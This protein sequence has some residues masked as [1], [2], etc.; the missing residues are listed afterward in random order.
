MNST[1]NLIQQLPSISSLDK[2]VTLQSPTT[3]RSASGGT[4]DSWADTWTD[5]ARVE[6]SV[7]GNDELI[8][9][10]QSMV[11]YRLKI[12]IRYR[13]TVT[14]KMRFKYDVDGSGPTYFDILFKE[15]LGRRQ[16]EKFTCE[17][18]E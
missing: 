5:W 12:T 9:G 18:V 15:I 8:I 11:R 3:T 14:E 10:D 13:G 7:T 6:Y 17:S 4:I 2:R 1:D 16:F